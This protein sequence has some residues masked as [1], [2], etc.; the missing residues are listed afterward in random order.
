MARRGLAAWVW[1]GAAGV[2]LLTGAA[3]IAAPVPVRAFTQQNY[4]RMV[5]DW[6]QKVEFTAKVEG[7]KLVVTFDQPIETSLDRAVRSVNRFLAGGRV[8]TDG[9]SVE[10]DLRRPVTL[11]S[12]RSGNAVA[13]D[14]VPTTAEAAAA[15]PAAGAQ[16]AAAT[17]APARSA[18]ARVS[19]RA[20]DHPN[21]TRIVFD[22]PA[23][24]EYR[25]Q[26]DGAAV[27]VLFD[28]PGDLDAAQAERAKLRNVQNIES[29]RQPN[30]A[31]AI[32]FAAPQDADIRDF[33]NGKS[34]VIDVQ[35]AGTRKAP[36]AATAAAQTPEPK[37]ATPSATPS[38]PTSAPTSAAQAPA[39]AQPAPANASPPAAPRQAPAPTPASTPSGPAVA[40]ANAP[41]AAVAAPAASPAAPS[42]VVATGPAI[43]FDPG[44]PSSMAV[45]A[46]AGHLY[47]V[48]DKSLPIGAGKV[49]GPNAELVGGVE[50]VPATGGSAF[51]TRVGPFV[52]PKIERQGTVWRITPSTRLV[53]AGP[54]ELRVEPDPA[55]LMGARLLVRANDANAVVQLSDPDVGDRLMV[56][57]LPTAGQAVSEPRRFPDAELLPAFQGVVVRP[58]NDDLAVRPVR[59]GLEIG[60]PGGLHLSPL[61]DTGLRPPGSQPP[62]QTAAAGPAG[63][64]AGQRPTRRIYELDAWQ[65]G[66]AEHYT[67]ARQ[68]L[69]M[70]AA[71]A[72]DDL[73]AKAQL[74]LA[75]F[76][77]A[78]G[79][80]PE[81]LGML[82][83]VQ[84][85]QTGDLEAWPEFR[86]LRGAARVLAGDGDGALEDLKL[87]AFANNPEIGV[88][89]AA[90]AAQKGDWPA[91]AA[92]FKAG[93]AY[94]ATY[95]EPVLSRLALLAAEAALKTGD[96]AS[97]QRLIDRVLARGGVDA[98]DRADVQYLRGE[99]YRQLGEPDRA[100]EQ[101]KTAYEGLDRFYRAK[102]GLAL[103]DL[104][105]AE[106]RISPAAAVER[107]SGLTYAWRGDDLE[108]A[109]R[110]K[111]GESLLAGGQY[112]DGLNSMK[113]TAAIVADT[114]K[115][116]EITRKM[117][118]SFADLYKDGAAKLPTLDALK[119]YDQFRE[120]TPPGPE[121]DEVIRQLA[122]R[123]V[124][125]DML[126]RAA[127]LYEHQVQYR[128]AGEE[129][130][131]LGTRLASLRL[132]DQKSQDAIRA[133]EMSNVPGIPADLARER[134]LM[135]AKALAEL[136]R[137]D[138]ALQLLAEDDSRPADLLRVD[139]AWRGQKWEQAA[140]ALGKVIGAPPAPE[141]KLEPAA[142]QLVLNRAV[143]LALAGD[144]TGLNT[145]R[146]DFGG[147]M[148]KGPDADAFRILTR[149]EQ[150]TGLIDVNT[151]RSRVA[152][153]DVFKNFLKGYRTRQAQ[154]PAP[155]MN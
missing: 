43:V 131:R 54:Q 19:V 4:A 80:G 34:V 59:E 83:V 104:E 3:A 32:T 41:T 126:G 33:K 78:N 143:A 138:E 106:N 128:S 118:Q 146:K 125:I 27:T 46:R 57:P 93:N 10:F 133:L 50:P 134:R 107:L 45:F 116:E 29:Y 153:V 69:Q 117:Q 84:G 152:E 9:R 103:T 111:L 74:D 140:V 97:A 58:L 151:I 96:T 90:V 48:F 137:G 6:P 24:A 148:A 64:A 73:R 28:R 141:A 87:P 25:V 121:G 122:E 154:A 86:A 155:V 38:A 112:A 147:A 135:Q 60:A 36:E 77:L 79:F 136:G 145:L 92:G 85:T 99:L 108:L 16:T 49:N 7:E 129:K 37:P 44:G 17:P 53:N 105:L 22:W 149:P 20:A 139:I 70:A 8:G 62:A 66:G 68:Q 47:M 98:E 115:A 91:A 95:P 120:L 14:L 35:N 18:A 31:L 26:R 88:W 76:Y 2:A 109:I 21:Y 52:W 81:T 71:E 127:D 119:L 130:A 100:I 42:P 15:A 12:F 30:G 132:L 51:R 113:E 67:D 55:F 63:P 101:L 5:F 65:H 94:L 11:K 56:A 124:T 72:P 39:S 1:V 23:G 114:P 61:A 13:I 142:S 75:K 110:Q 89:R 102:A 40:A 82:E 150:A 144:G 123:L